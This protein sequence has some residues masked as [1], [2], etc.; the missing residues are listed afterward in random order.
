MNELLT[1]LQSWQQPV[2]WLLITL[3]VYVLALKIF[4]VLGRRS[5]FH[6]LLL[7]MGI[8]G[9]ILLI[10]QQG[11]AEYQQQVSLLQWFLGP[12]TVALAVPLFKQL[13]G[14]RRKA[15]GVLLP[16]LVGGI[17]APL[18]A[19]I[20][21]YWTDMDR[22]LQITM[23]SKS[24]TTPLAMDTARLIGGY[25][26]LAAVIVIL[27]GIVAAVVSPLV[28][29]LLSIKSQQ[30]QGLALG[31]VAHA[32]GAAQGLQT[33]EKSAAFATLALCVNGVLSAIILP[34]LFLWLG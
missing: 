1:Q 27:T 28:F 31:T 20:C 33:S 25:P 32:I 16:I 5:F 19:F 8:L 14:L 13:T 12:A 10:S 11:L 24:I 30:A 22:A 18:S 21:L 23:L 3:L 15:S 26:E 29:R 6:P 4:D 9:L 2:S 7:C 17:V 34:L